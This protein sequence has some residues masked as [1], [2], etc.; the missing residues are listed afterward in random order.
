[1][2]Q[3]EKLAF[4]YRNDLKISQ[5]SPALPFKVFLIHFSFPPISNA[6][7]KLKDLSLHSL[8]I[9]TEQSLLDTRRSEN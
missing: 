6:Q 4:F 9:E 1:M 8:T 5:L 2:S 3:V 7:V